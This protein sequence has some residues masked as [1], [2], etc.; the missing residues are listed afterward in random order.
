MDDKEYVDRFGK[1]DGPV[2]DQRVPGRK[3]S[4]YDVRRRGERAGHAGDSEYIESEPNPIGDGVKRVW[5]RVFLIFCGEVSRR[6]G[7]RFFI[8]YDNPVAMM[9]SRKK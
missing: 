8:A 6:H 9:Y 4:D 7:R 1:K 2:P 3:E 5:G